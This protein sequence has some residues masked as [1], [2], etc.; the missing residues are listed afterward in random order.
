MTDQDGDRIA[1]ENACQKPAGNSRRI[2]SGLCKNLWDDGPLRLA[3]FS[4]G[5]VCTPKTS[6][7]LG[8]ALHVH[9]LYICNT[10]CICIGCAFSIPYCLVHLRCC[11]PSSFLGPFEC[12]Y[13]SYYV[14]QTC[15]KSVVVTWGPLPKWL[16]TQLCSVAKSIGC[17]QRHL[18]V[19]LFICLS[20]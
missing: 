7:Q 4:S 11:R 3:T 9:I 2:K 8:I 10:I 15:K 13:H 14:I 16:I 18:F 17:Y 20:T 6:A 5:H 12:K 19:C 1:S